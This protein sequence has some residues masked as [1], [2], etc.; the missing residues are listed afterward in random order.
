MGTFG[1]GELYIFMGTDANRNS[2]TWHFVN[3]DILRPLKLLIMALIIIG[4]I[5]IIKYKP[6][7]NLALDHLTDLMIPKSTNRSNLKLLHILIC[8]CTDACLR[9]LSDRNHEHMVQV[10]LGKC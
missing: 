8:E 10:F 5:A 2:H 4:V 7:L 1:E 6:C 9:D 3:G